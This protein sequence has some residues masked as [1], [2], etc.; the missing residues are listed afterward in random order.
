MTQPPAKK[1]NSKSEK[2]FF[3]PKKF[4]FFNSRKIN[5]D[6]ILKLLITFTA[7]VIGSS[8]F[9]QIISRF[10]SLNSSINPT[11]PNPN[12]T[13][14][15]TLSPQEPIA[16]WKI[17]SDKHIAFNYPSTWKTTNFPQPEDLLTQRLDSP[18]NIYSLTIITRSNLNPTTQKPY[19]NPRDLVITPPPGQVQQMKLDNLRVIKIIPY[20]ANYCGGKKINRTSLYFISSDR[21]QIYTLTFA[22]RVQE[23]SE[24]IQIGHQTFDQI[25]STF[26]SEKLNCPPG[27]VEQQCKL[28]PC[29]CPIGALCD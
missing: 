27:Q 24:I 25:L 8:Y 9:T 18:D 23:N 1:P 20:T 15:Q 12:L 2:Q 4:T 3:N 29:C 6:L 10:K 14:T 17:Y 16:N 26:T 21:Q 22:I 28:G 13:T 7:I 5:T 11:A 19:I